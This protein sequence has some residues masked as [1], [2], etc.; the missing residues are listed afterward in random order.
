MPDRTKSSM[1]LVRSKY[2]NFIEVG[3]S[4]F[5]TLP[6]IL[7]CFFLQLLEKDIENHRPTIDRVL[8]STADVIRQ[9]KP[10]ER[11]IYQDK[12]DNFQD[13]F[14]DMTSSLKTHGTIANLLFIL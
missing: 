13:R 2:S 10:E 11:R 6:L 8:R 5:S 1:F 4:R 9:L 14:G 12:V 7:K 3:P